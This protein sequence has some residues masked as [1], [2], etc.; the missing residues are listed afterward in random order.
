MHQN[1]AWANILRWRDLF[2]SLSLFSPNRLFT[3]KFS[4]TAKLNGG[5]RDFHVLSAPTYVQP[6][7]LS[8]SISNYQDGIFITVDEPTWTHRYHP[9]SRVCLHSLGFTLCVV[10]SLFFL[11][12]HSSGFDKRRM[13]CVHRYTIVR[14]SFTALKIFCSSLTH[15]SPFADSWQ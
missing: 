7:M 12:F 15:L 5:H 4:F 1:C 6:P 13:T 10:H 11:F 8:T 9:E 3:S 2:F 14:G